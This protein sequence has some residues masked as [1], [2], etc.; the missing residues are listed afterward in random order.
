[1]VFVLGF[2]INNFYW[3]FSTKNIFVQVDFNL[4]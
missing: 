3:I 4:K 1:M 2:I